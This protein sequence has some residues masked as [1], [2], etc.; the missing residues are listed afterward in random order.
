MLLCPGPEHSPYLRCA[1]YLVGV[2]GPEH[3]LHVGGLLLTGG[4]VHTEDPLE[5]VQVEV[6]T[7]AFKGKF[8]VELLNVL[9]GNFLIIDALCLTHDVTCQTRIIMK[10]HKQAQ[11]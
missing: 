6:S 11:P 2:K 3:V 7:R 8:A 5:L 10:K 4:A 9:K 1:T